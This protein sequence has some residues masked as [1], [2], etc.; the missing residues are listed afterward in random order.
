MITCFNLLYWEPCFKK[1]PKVCN[2]RFQRLGSLIIYS[3]KMTVKE[4]Q[5]N[6][7]SK[8]AMFDLQRNPWNLCMFVLYKDMCK[9]K[10]PV[11]PALYWV[12]TVPVHS[13][14]AHRHFQRGTWNYAYSPFKLWNGLL[15]IINGNLPNY[16]LSSISI[17]GIVS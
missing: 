13:G 4:F 5:V 9:L 7:N 11:G 10:M 12:E 3:I 17:V 16:W 6:L 8:T 1:S 2:I 15:H 14:S